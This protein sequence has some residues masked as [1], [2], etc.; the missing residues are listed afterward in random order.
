MPIATN[1]KCGS[2]AWGWASACIWVCA[3][4]PSELPIISSNWAAFRLALSVPLSARSNRGVITPSALASERCWGSPPQSC[5]S[6]AVAFSLFLGD[7]FRTNSTKVGTAFKTPIAVFPSGWLASIARMANASSTISPPGCVSSLISMGTSPALTARPLFPWYIH[8]LKSAV[9]A[10]TF[11]LRLPSLKSVTSAGIAPDAPRVTLNSS[12]TERLKTVAAAFSR[13]S[14]LPFLSTWRILGTASE[15]MMHRLLSS[16]IDKF[17]RAV[18]ACSW[19]RV[20]GKER[21]PIRRG[22]APA[23]AIKTRL[24]PLCLARRRSSAARK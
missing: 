11:P 19:V 1:G 17:R 3:L 9:A 12:T 5:T 13:A 2:W 10:S 20:S 4:Y 6:T 21:R 7:P 22:M 14:I 15:D 8:K 24:S 16:Q 23:S 18:T